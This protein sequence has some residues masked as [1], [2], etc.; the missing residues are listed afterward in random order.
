MPSITSLTGSTSV[1]SQLVLLRYLPSS[2][3]ASL[4]KK[5]LT[6]SFNQS[7]IIHVAK[8]SVICQKHLLIL[9][10]VKTPQHFSAEVAKKPPHRTDISIAAAANPFTSLEWEKKTNLE[11]FSP[12]SLTQP[13]QRDWC[14]YCYTNRNSPYFMSRNTMC[15]FL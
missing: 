8:H 12:C 14:K 10:E 4:L 5:G 3:K 9:N 7:W 13:A 11:G 6:T 2:R 15:K 1:A